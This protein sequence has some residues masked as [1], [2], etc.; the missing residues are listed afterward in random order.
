M[1]PKFWKLSQGSEYFTFQEFLKSIDDHLVYVGKDTGSKGN[2]PISQGEDFIKTA[3]IGDYF[4]LTHGNTGGVY[5]LGQLT[6]PANFLS[7]YPDGWVDRPF[8]VIAHAKTQ[9]VYKG[10]EKWWTPNHRSTFVQIPDDELGLF[11][12]L[13]LEPYFGISLEKYGIK[14]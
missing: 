5:L 7:A 13:I 3:E 2:N 9:E 6:G 11:Q 8:R 1:R 14:I 4:Y 10:Q 12:E